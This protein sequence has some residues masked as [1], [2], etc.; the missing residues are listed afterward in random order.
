M[1]Y[2]DYTQTALFF[3]KSIAFLDL[4]IYNIGNK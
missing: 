2:K 4:F 3:Q 1:T